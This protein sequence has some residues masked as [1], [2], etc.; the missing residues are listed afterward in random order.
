MHTI[1]LGE[2]TS[3]LKYYNKSLEM[4][5]AV[6]GTVNHPDIAGSYMNMSNAYN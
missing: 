5:K 3:A 2:Y 1:E 6:F 4:Y